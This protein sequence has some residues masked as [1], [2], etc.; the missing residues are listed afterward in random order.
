M[1][2][3]ALTTIDQFPQTMRQQAAE[4]LMERLG[5]NEPIAARAVTTPCRLVVRESA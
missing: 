2:M 1:F 5:S 4:L 3:S